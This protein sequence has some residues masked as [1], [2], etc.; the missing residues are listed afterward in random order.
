MLQA[1][2]FLHMAKALIFLIKLYRIVLSPWVG[3]QCRFYPTCSVYAEQ[4]LRKYGTFKGIYLA[5]RRIFKCHPW[6]KGPWN[7]H[8]P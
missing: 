3:N 1:R 5:I 7:D 2:F 4:A 8:V 6:H